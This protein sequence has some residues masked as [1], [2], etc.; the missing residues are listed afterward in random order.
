MSGTIGCLTPGAVGS[1]TI[2][3]A[4]AVFWEHAWG[5]ESREKVGATAMSQRKTIGLIWLVAVAS[6]A[7]AVAEGKTPDTVAPA[8]AVVVQVPA[9]LVVKGL[10]EAL[11]R[12]ALGPSD[13]ERKDQDALK[14]FYAARSNAPLWVVDGKL[15]TRADKAMAEMSASADY[16]LD[17][18]DFPLPTPPGADPAKLA[19]AD[20]QLSVA[21]LTYARYA[22]GGRIPDPAEMLSTQLDR[23][24]Q[25]IDPKQVLEDLAKS[26]EPGAYLRS[27]NPKHEQFERL[28]QLYVKAL[29]KDGKP[30]KLSKDAKR[31]R[32]N[33][34]MWRWLP[35]DMGT[36]LGVGK[37]MYVFNNIP[38]F[39]QYVYK[40]GQVVRTERIVA[41]QLDKQSA[42][43]SRPLKYV[44]LRPQ[45]RVPESIK[46]NELWPSL[47]RN[48]GYMR[49]FALEVQTKDGAAVDW[50]K[51][52]WTSTDIREYEVV[53]PSG[54]KNVL[55]HVKFS[56]PS[57]HTIYMHDTPDKYMFN[58]ARRTLSHGC[59][60]VQNPMDLARMIL[61]EDKG[62][63]ADKVAELDKSGPLNNEIAIDKRIP[64]HLVYF[65]Q[66]VDDNGKLKSFADVYGHEKRVIQGLDGKWD[67]VDHGYDHLA[68]VEVKASGDLVASGGDATDG[69]VDTTKSKGKGKSQDAFGD[70]L[71]VLFGGP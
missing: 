35:D 1:I 66:W 4:H 49:K 17:P 46:V 44:V 60:R 53:Q 13:P 56:F 16:A 48:G 2:E 34:E 26:D 47:K 21:A 57:Q 32:A 18:K 38:E 41:G 27:L 58:A 65:T 63:D 12:L 8:A 22:R 61:K 6:A 11:G 59:L 25:W 36:Q 39:M 55:G 67:A 10:D 40:D 19:A 23:R 14:A 42:I 51:I 50:K 54:P 69:Q 5:A 33:M 37:G 7:P 70:L 71:S 43:F 64:I 30:A 20:L 15:T 3:R 45:W 24:P 28:R 62:W 68:P 31:L 9:D 29:P 52:D